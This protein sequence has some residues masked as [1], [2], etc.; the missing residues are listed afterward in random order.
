MKLKSA[1]V[2]HV[3]TTITSTCKFVCMHIKKINIYIY[4]QI[5]GGGFNC[6]SCWW[7]AHMV[8][9]HSV[10]LQHAFLSKRIRGCVYRVYLVFFPLRPRCVLQFQYLFVDGWWISAIRCWLLQTG[11][12]NL[13]N[14][15]NE[16]IHRNLFIPINTSLIPSHIILHNCPPNSEKW[17]NMLWTS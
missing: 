12:H 8:Y 17:K 11:N 9:M 13:Q 1:K 10:F 15:Y 4:M 5:F 14:S 3:E 2:V 16:V 6:S 7:I